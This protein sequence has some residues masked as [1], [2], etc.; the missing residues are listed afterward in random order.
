MKRSLLIVLILTALLQGISGQDRII[1]STNDTIDCRITRI[2]NDMIFF[3]I[4]TK[5]VKSEGRIPVRDISSYQVTPSAMQEQETRSKTSFR[6]GSFRIAIN[7][8]IGYITSSTDAAEEAMASLGVTERNAKS[9]YSDLKTGYYGSADAIWMFKTGYGAGIRYKFFNT[10]AT[11]EGYFDPG[12]GINIIFSD[13]NENI[14]VNYAGV[15][16]FYEQH[17]GKN[18]NLGIYS[19]LSLGMA[20]YLNLLDF[21]GGNLAISGNTP[22]MDAGIGLEYRIT[23]VVSAAAEASVFTGT[24][25]KIKITDG[26]NEES[27]DLDKENYENL[28]RIEF[29]LGIRFYFGKR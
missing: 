10:D 23:P 13:Y 29:S 25:R 11:T 28:S 14:F 9:Y 12:D 3:E 22:G 21:Y 18:G 8:G 4:S 20:F 27:V 7:G 19:S 15:S 2:T 5:G 17:A 1:T 6:S 26:V 16:L 24:I